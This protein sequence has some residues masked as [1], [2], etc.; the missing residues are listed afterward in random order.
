METLSL[1]Q[2]GLLAGQCSP[3]LENY[4]ALLEYLDYANGEIHSSKANNT[5]KENREEDDDDED[6]MFD[7]MEKACTLR[8]LDLDFY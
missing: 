7:R 8:I 3:F 4:S 2:L 6:Y 5:T 1:S